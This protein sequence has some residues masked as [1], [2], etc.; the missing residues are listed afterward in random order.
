MK[1]M[2]GMAS[3]LL[4]GIMAL[5]LMPLSTLSADSIDNKIQ[6]M[7]VDGVTYF[8]ASSAHFEDSN[9]LFFQD[10]LSNQNAILQSTASLYPDYLPPWQEMTAPLSGAEL[11]VLR[12]ICAN[13]SNAEIGAIL[14]IKVST[15]KTH[16]SN[17]LRKLGV[18]RRSEAEEIAERLHLIH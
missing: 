15:V 5:S 14:D 4:A 11:Q 17:I 2:K 3:T 9:R 8:N 12:L 6:E 1:R 18:K 10:L 16:V 13:K 7:T